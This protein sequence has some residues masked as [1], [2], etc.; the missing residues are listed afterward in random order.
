[1]EEFDIRHDDEEG[2]TSGLGDRD[3][4]V[5]G[6]YLK[7][8]KPFETAYVKLSGDSY[9][10]ANKVIPVLDQLHHDLTCLTAEMITKEL[11]LERSGKGEPG[12]VDLWRQGGEGH[13][14][15]TAVLANF[16]KR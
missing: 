12:A 13:T 8:V 15:V 14:L 5:I 6:A 7:V 10:T 9:P 11:K 1:V 3:W 4:V 2:E 16:E